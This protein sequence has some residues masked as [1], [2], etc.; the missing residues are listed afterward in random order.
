MAFIKNVVLSSVDSSVFVRIWRIAVVAFS[1]GTIVMALEIAGSRLLTP[2]FG[3]STYTWGILIGIILSG[4][5]IGYHIGGRIADSNPSFQKLCSVV[6]STGI[7][8]LFVP[9][10][11]QDVIAFLVDSATE[12]LIANLLSTTLLFGLPTILL[13]FVSPYAIKLGAKSLSN[14]GTVSGNLYSVATLGSIFG[15]FLTVFV[16]VPFFEINNLILGLGITLIAISLLGL[17]KIPIVITGILVVLI[18]MGFEDTPFVYPSGENNILVLK[19]T[20]YSSLLVLEEENFR[21]MYLDGAVH[22]S[23]DMNDP[24][25]LVVSY[26]RAFHLAGLF[27]KN[28][29]DVLFVGGGGFS[30]PKSFL[31]TYPNVKV[32]VVEIDPEVIKAA[33][34]FFFVPDDPRLKIINQDAR[35]YLSKS[36]KKYDAIILDAYSGYTIPYHLMTIEY[37]GL[38]SERLNENGI[39]ISNFLG[40][41]DGDDSK[42]LDSTYKTMN[43]IFPNV[44][45][46][47]GNVKNTDYRQNITIIAF[48]EQDISIHE[49]FSS[50]DCSDFP[51]DC[52][53]L[54]KNYLNEVNV[55]ED[56]LLLSD[57]L[58]PVNIIAKPEQKSDFYEQ[59]KLKVGAYDFLST[60]YVVIGLVFCTIVWSYNLQR[61]WKS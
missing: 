22:S 6:F 38:L 12:P 57:Q 58:S 8:I 37:Y 3:S 20:P 2:I 33:K 25:R 53:N 23:M 29:E 16:L 50:P 34:K 4:L 55:S 28:L 47:P 44:H 41:L 21:T 46:F 42:L 15:T 5:T 49:T 36:E 9:Y 56:A 26:T 51:F 7:F 43:Q 10:I 61:I 11:A 32:D 13:G 18:A 24:A 40:S 30:G 48:K 19:E 39:V 54:I 17:G 1:S 45:V 14:I 27:N 31:S 59:L 35:L 60:Q 52:D